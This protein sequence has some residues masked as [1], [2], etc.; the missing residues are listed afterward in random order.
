[1]FRVAQRRG[2]SKQL[3]PGSGRCARMLSFQRLDVYECSIQFLALSMRLGE[4]A[5]TTKLCR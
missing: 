3:D 2:A 4:L 5:M 1:M